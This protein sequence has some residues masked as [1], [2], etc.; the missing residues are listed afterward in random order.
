MINKYVN[1]STTP[2]PSS[3]SRHHVTVTVD[4][5]EMVTDT[6]AS[7]FPRGT[8]HSRRSSIDAAEAT[9]APVTD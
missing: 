1:T 7:R 5:E 8:A 3:P 4:G 2:P 6:L 9:P